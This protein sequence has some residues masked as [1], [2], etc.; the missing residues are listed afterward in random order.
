MPPARFLRGQQLP[1]AQ[2]H[3]HYGAGMIYLKLRQPAASVSPLLWLHFIPGANVLF[4]RRK[5]W[6]GLEG[7]E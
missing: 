6:G 5:G 2:R 3:R 7:A 1:L 4:A